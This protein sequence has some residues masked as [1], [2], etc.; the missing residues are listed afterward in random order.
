MLS[1]HVKAF[2]CI[3]LAFVLC[4]QTALAA[5][6]QF[7]FRYTGGT[8]ETKVKPDDW[9]NTMTVTSDHI[10]LELKDG[11]KIT[12][13]PQKVNRLTYGQNARRMVGTMIALSLINPLALFGLFHK[14]RSHFVGIEYS[15]A[16]GK[17]GAVLVQADKDQYR[18]MLTALSGVTSKQVETITDKDPKQ[19]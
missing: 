13:D 2:I 15:T 3:L 7:K 10:L 18:A 4:S 14:K 8:T 1:P 17:N 5:G 11:Q 6:N 12:I 19:K 9:H 16:E